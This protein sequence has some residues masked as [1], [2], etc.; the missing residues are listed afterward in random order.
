[1]HSD[2]LLVDLDVA[3]NQFTWP[4]RIRLGLDTEG[5][6]APRFA[7]VIHIDGIAFRRRPCRSD[8]TRHSSKPG[9]LA[10]GCRRAGLAGTADEQAID[11][12]RLDANAGVLVLVLE[13]A[14]WTAALR[15]EPEGGLRTRA[16]EAGHEH[17]AKDVIAEGA[18]AA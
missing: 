3:S 1:M 13:I 2:L 18:S 14:R 4:I 7:A 17:R 10:S 5:V 6:I 16:G 8:H 15:H 9:L 11:I 12:S